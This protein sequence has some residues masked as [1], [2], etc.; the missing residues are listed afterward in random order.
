MP[1]TIHIERGPMDHTIEDWKY[2]GTVANATAAVAI[3][4]AG[5]ANTR[6]YISSII[7]SGYQTMWVQVQ[8]DAGTPNVAI[9][10]THVASAG[11][12]AIIEFP[13]GRELKMG[14]DNQDI[15]VIADASGTIAYTIIGYKTK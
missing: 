4:A 1:R 11:V 3:V 14:A 9:A 10:Y 12:P 15:D 13:P 6:H 5:G 8:D 7:L 2:A